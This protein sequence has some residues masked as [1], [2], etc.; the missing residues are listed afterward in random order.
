MKEET[1]HWAGPAVPLAASELADHHAVS[2]LAKIYGLGIDVRD[3]PLCRSA[4]ADD[5]VG[6]G[7]QGAEPIEGFLRKTYEIGAS[8]HA[9]Q[10]IISNQYVQ[11]RG[12]EATVWSYGVAH[13]KVAPGEARDEIIAGVQYR[14]ECRRTPQGWLIRQRQ[15]ALQW[16]DRG[17]PK[18]ST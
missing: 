8:F 1:R 17:R 14:D 2:Q 18:G 15:V 16:M 4:F 13:H 3:Y 11:L 6:L 9:T 10:H 5:A 12:D 7:Q